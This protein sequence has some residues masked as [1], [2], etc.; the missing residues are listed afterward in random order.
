MPTNR[1]RL[2]IQVVRGAVLVGMALAAGWIGGTVRDSA[3]DGAATPPPEDPQVVLAP[4]ERRVL[5][6]EL[7]ARGDV[8]SAA[9][10]AVSAPVPPEGMGSVVVTRAPLEVGDEVA[11]GAVVLELNGRPV[12][13]LAGALPVYRDL[14]P[15]DTGPDVGQVQASLRAGGASI[16]AGEDGRFGWATQEAVRRLYE[17]AGYE[18]RYTQGGRAEVERLIEEATL[19]V[20]LAQGGVDAAGSGDS[21]A[22]ASARASLRAA[23]STLAQRR[24]SEGIVLPGHEVVVVGE[25]PGVLIER[26]VTAGARTEPGSTVAVVG[27]TDLVVQVEVTPAQSAELDGQAVATVAEPSLDYEAACTIETADVTDGPA[28]AGE[29]VP[30]GDGDGAGVGA[31]TQGSGN[32]APVSGPALVL[33][34][35]PAPRLEMVGVNVRVAMTIPR[36]DGPV[37][38]VPAASVATDAAAASFVEVVDGE[39]TRRVQVEVGREAVGSVEVVAAAGGELREGMQVRVRSR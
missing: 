1:R 9:A 17:S 16:P 10:S 32:A 39:R 13:A 4:V 11:A 2:V 25:L 35:D 29:A 7:V 24:A 8:V 23:E 6:V 36:S 3:N 26:P 30:N 14:R 33:H 19:A 31:G 12:L 27:S 38:V 37:L 21:D 15:G 34:C 20:E 5:A 28:P 18:P 22:A